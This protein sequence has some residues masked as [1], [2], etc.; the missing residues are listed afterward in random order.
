MHFLQQSAPK[1]AAKQLLLHSIQ[2]NLAE[3]GAFARKCRNLLHEIQ[4]NADHLR[5]MSNLL[6]KI[7]SS[8]KCTLEINLTLLILDSAYIHLIEPHS[9][10]PDNAVA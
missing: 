9:Q 5:E 8:K 1:S 4:Q 6:H 3:K 10:Y 2:Q 7:H